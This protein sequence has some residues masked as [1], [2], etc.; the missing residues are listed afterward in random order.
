[1]HPASVLPFMPVQPNSQL[2]SLLAELRTDRFL[3]GWRDYPG[4]YI[5]I[6]PDSGDYFLNPN[7]AVAQQLACQKR[8]EQLICTFQLMQQE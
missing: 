7:K 1:M 6:E 3:L 5:A 4:W 2:A 8:S